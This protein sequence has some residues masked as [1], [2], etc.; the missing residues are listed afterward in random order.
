MSA[1]DKFQINQQSQR[2][3]Q[4]AFCSLADTDISTVYVPVHPGQQLWTAFLLR[5]RVG[6]KSYDA[7]CYYLA[8]VSPFVLW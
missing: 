1:L 8:N 6:R 7:Q 5:V 3:S 4:A 2:Q